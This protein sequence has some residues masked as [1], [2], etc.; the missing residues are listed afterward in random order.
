MNNSVILQVDESTKGLMREIQTG[1]TSSID[2]SLREVKD[3][4][5]TVDENTEKILH[6]FKNFDALSKSLGGLFGLAEIIYPLQSSIFEIKQ[7]TK[8]N[9]QILSETASNIQLLLEGVVE[10][11]DKQV[12]NNST[13]EAE[14]QKVLSRIS[15]DNKSLKDALGNIIEKFNQE[16]D[17]RQ[18][19]YDKLNV[20]LTNVYGEIKAVEKG[21]V[22]K[23][24]KIANELAKLMDSH[25]DFIIKYSTNEISRKTS[26]DSM[27]SQIATIK[28]SLDKVQT[29]LDVVINLVTPFSQ[30]NK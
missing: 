17:I 27:T 9:E 23:T 2:D 6:K 25:N 5:E 26:E 7:G 14:L 12:K 11:L 8:T 18:E 30:D 13:I 4:V 1:I 16:D 3:K 28:K 21:F 19:L 22:E 10:L 24:D 29:S 15:E 20:T